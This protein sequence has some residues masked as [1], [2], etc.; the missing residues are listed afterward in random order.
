MTP[1]AD[2][3]VVFGGLWSVWG[4]PGER[5][6]TCS[7]VTTEATG[8]LRR[9]HDRMPLF[10]GPDRWRSWLTATDDL[11]LAS[12]ATERDRNCGVGDPTGESGSGFGP[13]RRS[14]LITRIDDVITEPVRSR[15]DPLLAGLLSELLHDFPD[16]LANLLSSAL[17]VR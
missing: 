1:Y 2:V 3:P 14:G 11:S 4:P 12:G 16:T 5:V 10:L 9:V 15:S 13:Q 7:I 6:L 17:I 8:E